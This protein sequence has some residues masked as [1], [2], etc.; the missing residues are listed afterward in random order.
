MDQPPLCGGGDLAAVSHPPRMV[1]DGIDDEGLRLRL[2]IL[3][4]LFAEFLAL[5]ALQA[6]LVGLLGALERFGGAGLCGLCRGRSRIRLGG[7]RSGCLREN[8][9]CEKQERGAE[10]GGHARRYRHEKSLGVKYGRARLRHHAEPRMNGADRK[11][12]V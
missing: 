12:V 10:H 2:G 6:F 3:D 11:S 4:A 9:R 5:F 7:R 1:E 8:G